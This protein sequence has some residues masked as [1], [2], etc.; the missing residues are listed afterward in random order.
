MKTVAQ[1]V[2]R[3]PSG[4]VPIDENVNRLFRAVH[5]LAMLAAPEFVTEAQAIAKRADDEYADAM[6]MLLLNRDDGSAPAES[7]DDDD[8]PIRHV[9]PIEFANVDSLVEEARDHLT[10]AAGIFA[11]VEGGNRSGD[12]EILEE[13]AEDLARDFNDAVA[14]CGVALGAARGS[15]RGLGDGT[16][17][18]YKRRSWTPRAVASSEAGPSSAAAE[19]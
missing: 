5:E 7:T 13:L 17:H 1:S 4:S 19:E 14:A 8:K 15:L 10:K 12:G 2:T 3:C 9:A 11:I 16:H 18:S 6:R